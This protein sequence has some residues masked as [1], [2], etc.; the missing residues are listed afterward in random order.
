MFFYE[1][2]NE[3]IS[4]EC[5]LA[6][7]YSHAST[8]SLTQLFCYFE[9]CEASCWL[10]GNNNYIRFTCRHKTREEREREEKRENSA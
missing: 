8:P 1:S 4:R 7:Y 10:S 3:V 2:A 5:H 9:S 6:A